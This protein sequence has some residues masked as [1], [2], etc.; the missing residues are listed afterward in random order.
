MNNTSKI[1]YLTAMFIYG[2]VAIFSHYILLSPTL[3]VLTRAVLGVLVI[4]VYA[5]IF[6]KQKIDFTAIKNNILWLILAGIALGLNWVC[7]FTSYNYTTV[8]IATLLNYLAPVIMILL[9]PLLLKEHLSIKKIICVLIAVIGM[10]FVT[11]PIGLAGGI[12]RTG[13]LLG[14]GSALTYVGLIVFNKYMKDIDP[15]SKTSFVLLIASLVIFPFM[16]FN[17]DFSVI[18]IDYKMIILLLV[19]GIIHTGFAYILYFGSMP[20][21]DGQTISI[22]SYIEPVVSILLSVIIL[23]ENMTIYTLIGTILILGATFISE[24]NLNK[25]QEKT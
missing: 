24:L 6:K 7:L 22:L 16:M 15:Y 12:N 2:T 10:V 21:L 1:K 8:A 9:S 14:L 11:D 13:L 4:L 23:R 19:I 5:F 17:T 3:I 18:E 25:N 20:N